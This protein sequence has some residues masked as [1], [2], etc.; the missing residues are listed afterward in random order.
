MVDQP[1]F[2]QQKYPNHM[3]FEGDDGL[4]REIWKVCSGSS[5]DVP[6]AGER[7]YYFPRLHV[8]QVINFRDFF[9]SF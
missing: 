1:W 4:R 6:K 8:E 7:V 9:D 5:L 3:S 2:S